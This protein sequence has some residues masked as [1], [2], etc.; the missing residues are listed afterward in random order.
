MVEEMGKPIGAAEAE[1][2]K[3]AWACR[4]YAEN[5][6]ALL[7][8]RT[9]VTD[10]SRSFVRF[11]PLGPVLAVM[12]WNFPFWQVFRFAAPALMAGNVGLL[13]HASNTTGC[14]FAIERIFAEAGL[15]DGT[16]Q[17]L[18]IRSHAVERVIR[19]PR[20]RAV[21]L[22]GSEPAGRAVSAAASDEVKKSVLELGGS[23]PF[24][25]LADA[26]VEK[27]AEVGAQARMIN[28][29]QSCIAAKRF[30][31]EEAVKD[32]FVEAFVARVADMKVGDPMKRETD[33]GPL[34]RR[35]LVDDLQEQVKGSLAAG[36][37]AELGGERLDGPGF[38]HAP[39]VLVD[40]T[41]EQPAFIEETFGP[42]AAIVGAADEDDALRLANATP[43]GLGASLWT[44]DIEK[45]ERL[46]P[47]VEA[48]AVFVN[49]LV[50]SDPRLPF[51]G[52]KRSGFGREL[53]E[54]G[55]RE[56]VNVKSV[57]IG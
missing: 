49:G 37:R 26:D 35:D 50:K 43:F 48:G 27:A 7:A 47:L 25:V 51:G 44:R 54:E 14:A 19:D 38:F 21:T 9:V 57:W 6:E 18:A 12:P 41:P 28:S 17:V 42:V 33:I 3:C 29:G 39:T 15:P 52:V 11:D 53:G 55:I 16:F 34:A 13:K 5:G 8:P 23:D 56:F 2:A 10:A 40:V 30:I 20:V 31:V 4:H 36:A 46:V 24:V 22:T 32:A 45:A 1:V